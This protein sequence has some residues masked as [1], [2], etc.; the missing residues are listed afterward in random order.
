MRRE[1]RLV[2]ATAFPN[3]RG[4]ALLTENERQV[5]GQQPAADLDPLDRAADG[6]PCG[7]GA[8]ADSSKNRHE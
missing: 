8:A 6:R 7:A 3:F 5:W 4:T 1:F 2:R